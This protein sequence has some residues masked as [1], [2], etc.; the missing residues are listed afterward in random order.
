MLMSIGKFAMSFNDAVRV[1]SDGLACTD[2][3]EEL[4]T[5][6][7]QLSKADPEN[8]AAYFLVSGFARSYV[9]LYEEDAVPAEQAQRAKQQLTR[10]LEM[11]ASS[12]MEG[13]P[14]ARLSAL[15]AVVLDYLQSD[16]I[17]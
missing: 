17:F 4:K 12:I 14:S 11:L 5:R 2:A 15:N 1:F 6:C 16:R 7:L 13:S 10:Y 8:A 3:Y 9:L